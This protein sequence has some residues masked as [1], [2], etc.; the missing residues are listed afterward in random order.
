VIQVHVFR[1]PL[2]EH[3]HT[4]AVAALHNAYG[5]MAGKHPALLGLTINNPPQAV[6]LLIR[7]SGH[8]RW[9][10]AHNARLFAA[11]MARRAGLPYKQAEWVRVE[12]EPTARHLTKDEGREFSHASRGPVV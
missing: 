6:E 9:R 10:V 11:T 2:G 12:S 7:A 8:D 1:V 4:D 3:T 5:I